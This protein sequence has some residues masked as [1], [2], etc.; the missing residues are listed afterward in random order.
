[1]STTSPLWVNSRQHARASALIIATV[2][3]LVSVGRLHIKIICK[4]V[5]VLLTAPSLDVRARKIGVMC[6]R[7]WIKK[8]NQHQA[9]VPTG[10]IPN[11][12]IEDCNTAAWRIILSWRLTVFL[13]IL[14]AFNRNRGFITVSITACHS[15]LSQA[16][17]IQSIFLYDRNCLLVPSLSET[18][19]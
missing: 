18:L 17:W 9:T 6:A 5:E 16:S 4:T 11:P 8:L 12:F 14:P 13:K 19:L 15:T 2:A 7:Y 3:V 10:C 1:M